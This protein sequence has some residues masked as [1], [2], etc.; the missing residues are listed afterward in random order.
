MVFKYRSRLLQKVPKL[1]INESDKGISHPLV[2]KGG[3][4]P[5]Q[6]TTF[7]VEFPDKSCTIDRVCPTMIIREKKLKK[8]YYFK[9]AAIL[10]IFVLRDCAIPR[11]LK[12]KT[13]PKA[14]F[15]EIWLKVAGRL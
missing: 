15:N 4:K 7:P 10:L 11:K 5:L 1:I 6:K 12:K 14:N 2:P 3:R 13:L 8:V 9:M